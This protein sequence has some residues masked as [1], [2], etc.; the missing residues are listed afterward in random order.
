MVDNLNAVFKFYFLI[1]KESQKVWQ[2]PGTHK[3]H[4]PQHFV[5]HH[6]GADDDTDVEEEEE[7]VKQSYS[8]RADPETVDESSSGKSEGGQEENQKVSE[9]PAPGTEE[10]ENPENIST[11]IEQEREEAA[12]PDIQDRSIVKD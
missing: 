3:S 11:T 2:K 9:E 10:Y 4:G 1:L 7:R 6:P 8:P 12:S 5:S